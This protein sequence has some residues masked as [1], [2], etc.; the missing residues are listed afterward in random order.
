[1][2]SFASRSLRQSPNLIRKGRNLLTL[3]TVAGVSRTS[4]GQ[5]PTL[6]GSVMYSLHL[7]R[8]CARAKIS[9]I[10]IVNIATNVQGFCRA[11]ELRAVPNFVRVIKP[12]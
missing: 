12:Q 8:K 4:E 2:V 7:R 10:Y 5:T 9:V 6:W 3:L 11:A 1:M